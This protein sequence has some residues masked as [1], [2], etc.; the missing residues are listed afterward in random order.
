MV[1]RSSGEANNLTSHFMKPEG[2]PQC[3]L[4]PAILLTQNNLVH[5]FQISVI[6]IH[7]NSP[8]INA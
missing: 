6:K 5:A 1:Q 8:L 2:S 3:T 7:F 4:E